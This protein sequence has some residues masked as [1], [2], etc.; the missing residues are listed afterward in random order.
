MRRPLIKLGLAALV[1]AAAG[2]GGSTGGSGSAQQITI[3]SNP[4]GTNVYTVAGGLA[5]LIQETA[6]IRST[7]RPFS[8]SSVYLPMLQRGEVALGLNT[9]IDGYLSYRGLPPYETPMTNLR[10]LGMMFPLNITFMVRADS[11][12]YRVEDLRGQRVVVRFRANVALEQLHRGILA[13][14]GL[15]FDDVE[16]M[17]VAGLGEAATAL[18][19]GRA[20]AVP[21]GIGTALGMETNAALSDGI[22]YLTMGQDEA[23]LAEVMPGTRVVTVAPR[24]NSV[25]IPGPIRVSGVPDMLNTGVHMSEDLAYEI[26]RTIHSNWDTLRG[27]VSLVAEIAAD[28]LAPADNMH[29]YHP[30]AVRYYREVGLWTD[31]HEQ[32][33]AALLALA[34]PQ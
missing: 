28:E 1:L 21:I 11:D 33:Q 22:R 4:A 13:T 7:I 17:T 5:K 29:P 15:G 12:L 24:E 31:A 26:I 34:A 8:G 20:D 32:N 18:R 10:T 14:G 9:N 27:D 6:G 3:A 23:R 25:G 16:A 19:E 30:G 2:C